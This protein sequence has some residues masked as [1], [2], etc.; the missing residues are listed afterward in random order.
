MP[1]PPSASSSES[2]A[3]GAIS[4]FVLLCAGIAAF[5][6]TPE[7]PTFDVS[8]VKRNELR[9]GIRGHSFPADRFEAT[10]V[11]LRDLIAIAYGE[12]GQLLPDTRLSGGP[13]W[14]D[15]DRFDVSARAGG[16]GP[17]SVAQ[18]QRMLRAL[19]AERFKLAV[20][21]RTVTLPI[22]ALV[23]ASRAGR[24]GPRLRQAGIDCEAL[25]SQQPGARER[26]ILYALPS[27]QLVVRGQ[28]MS[29]IANA[30]ALL[31][32]R[33]VQDRTGLTGGFDADA[34][35][36]PE[37]LPG[38]SSSPPADRPPS[39]LPSLVTTLQEQLGLE[40]ESTRA[41]VDV[42]VISHVERPTEN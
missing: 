4:V 20:Q 23:L 11:P 19:L 30:L 25:E 17:R 6:Q 15:S 13:T 37:G 1:A 9:R 31:L 3:A 8:S 18:K 22:Y 7:T 28:T 21:N 14:L 40:L 27:G 26:C 2:S 41:P 34:E 16:G 38:M 32:N 33:V 36:N 42:L 12:P 39:D 29:A 35:F 24:L 5:A 10:N